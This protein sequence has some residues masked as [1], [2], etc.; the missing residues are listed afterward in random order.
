MIAPGRIGNPSY[1]PQEDLRLPTDRPVRGEL[2]QLKPGQRVRAKA[3]GP[4]WSFRREGLAV[5]ADRVS[6]ENVDFVT[7]E[8]PICE[9]SA[10]R[11]L[12]P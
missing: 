3:D 7:E 6:F 5:Q 12:R 8:R 4:G 11:R 2:L 1:D 10:M 9:R